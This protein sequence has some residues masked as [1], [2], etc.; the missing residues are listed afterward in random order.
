[1][2]ESNFIVIV[3]W[4]K[5][6]NL[7]SSQQ[8]KATLQSINSKG[9]SL[10]FILVAHPPYSFILAPPAF[11]WFLKLKEVVKGQQFSSDA[12]SKVAVCNSIKSKPKKLTS[13][14]EWKSG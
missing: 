14:M 7:F 2:F 1:M 3:V 4:I 11:F 6:E 5:L 12:E 13:W 10:K 9:E 8:Y